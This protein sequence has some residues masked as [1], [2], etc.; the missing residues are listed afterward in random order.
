MAVDCG[1]WLAMASNI[2]SLGRVR[3]E[4]ILTCV[5]YLLKRGDERFDKGHEGRGTKV[6]VYIDVVPDAIKQGLKECV[7]EIDLNS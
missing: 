4:A 5:V 2:G 1:L 6:G 3:V 7:A